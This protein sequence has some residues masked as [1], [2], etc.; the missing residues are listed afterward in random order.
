[1][2]DTRIAFQ[3]IVCTLSGARKAYEVLAR[4]PVAGGHYEGP[5]GHVADHQW[6][7]LDLAIMEKLARW[8][9]AGNRLKHPLYINVSA[10][11]LS[12]DEAFDAWEDQY[13]RLRIHDKTPV[14]LEVNES[15]CSHA[16]DKRWEALAR[17]GLGIA[18]D[19]FGTELA[20][21][22]RLKAFPWSVCKFE[23]HSL[24]ATESQNALRYARANDMLTI[25]ERIETQQQADSAIQVGVTLHQGY[26]YSPPKVVALD[27]AVTSPRIL[28]S[29]AVGL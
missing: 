2:L 20:S 1:M 4:F 26:F 24:L 27:Y 23:S 5:H 19:D 9:A 10:Q 11:T 8:V 22:T 7:A 12:C 3:P 14:I 21:L 15:V 28:L 25:V 18:L 16:L 17:D 29:E 13:E 6:A